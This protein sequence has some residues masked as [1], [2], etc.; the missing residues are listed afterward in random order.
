MVFVPKKTIFRFT[1]LTWTA[2]AKT[3]HSITS[4]LFKFSLVITIS[5]T[6]RISIHPY[7]LTA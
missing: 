7:I 5:I 3:K 6:E 2:K 1:Y 4:Q